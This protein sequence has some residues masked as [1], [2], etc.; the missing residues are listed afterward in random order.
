MTTLNTVQ[1]EQLEPLLELRLQYQ[2]GMP[3]VISPEAGIGEY[4]GSGNGTVAG[5]RVQGTIYWDLFEVV[6]ERRCQTNF[7]GAIETE[8]GARIQFDARGYGMVIDRSRPDEWLMTSAVQFDTVDERY[9][10][11]NKTLAVWSGK[12]DMVT[13]RHHYQVYAST[14]S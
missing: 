13:Y 12:F 6:G 8:D 9:D 3:P 10:W 1:G 7:A 2:E 14:T 4:L 11:L 5:P